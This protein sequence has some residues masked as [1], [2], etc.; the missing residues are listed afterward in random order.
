MKIVFLDAK[1][2]GSDANLSVFEEFGEFI[3][4]PTST[5][6]EALKR[7]KDAQIIITNKV[8]IDKEMMDNATNLKLVCLSATGMNNVDLNYASQ[9]GIEVKNVAGYSTQSVAQYA[10][11]QVLSLV[12]R[13]AYYDEY[14]KSGQWT[15]SE[16]FTHIGR[17]F[18]DIEGKKWGIIGLGAIGKQVAHLASAFD[19]KVYYYSTSGK[20]KAQNYPHLE[21]DELLKTCDIVSVH[22]PLN[23]Q[24]KNLL[25]KEKLALLKQD[26]ILA[27]TARGGIVD[28]EALVDAINAKKIYASVDVLEEEPMSSSS[29]FL[30]LKEKERLLI[31]PHIAWASVE[32]RRRLIDGIAENIKT[33]LKG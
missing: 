26:A 23:E 16:I 29:P 20:N 19:V 9:K 4:Y 28:E 27:N 24:T 6:E 11:M 33:F 8:L 17:E 25:G 30:R 12:G 3:S 5:R 32:A 21:L 2:L 1:T 31:S 13:A 14:V 15:K 10:L 18:H 22:C 7:A